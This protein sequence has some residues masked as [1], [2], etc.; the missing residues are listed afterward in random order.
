MP[1]IFTIYLLHIYYIF[2]IYYSTYYLLGEPR[3]TE[4]VLVGDALR[5]HALKQTCHIIIHSGTPSYTVARHHAQSHE[6]T[7]CDTRIR[8]G[9][10]EGG[11]ALKQTFQEILKMLRHGDGGERAVLL[12]ISRQKKRSEKTFVVARQK[13]LRKKKQ[14]LFCHRKAE[15]LK[16]QCPSTYTI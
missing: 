13:K 11:D 12:V 3:V 9:L 10:G 15:I 6:D 5:G 1:Y 16:S 7:Q 14:I 4:E 2:H 8:E